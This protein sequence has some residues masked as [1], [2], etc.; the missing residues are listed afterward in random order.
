M[1]LMLRELLQ[2]LKSNF[3][4]LEYVRV[5]QMILYISFFF[6]N[7]WN[8]ISMGFNWMYIPLRNKSPFLVLLI[9][10]G[11]ICLCDYVAYIFISI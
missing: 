5:L 2:S 7:A 11:V 3:H 4:G 1:L 6:L 9:S 10:Q 8:R